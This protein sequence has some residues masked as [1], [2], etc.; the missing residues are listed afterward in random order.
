VEIRLMVSLIHFNIIIQIASLF[1]QLLE[2][3]ESYMQGL[4]SQNIISDIATIYA[5]CIE[6]YDNI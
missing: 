6:H 1:Q 5:T 4:V 3:E 2:L